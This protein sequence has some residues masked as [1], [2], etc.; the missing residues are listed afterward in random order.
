MRSD[1]VKAAV[2][3]GTCGIVAAAVLVVGLVFGMRWAIDS[4]LAG[5]LPP[6]QE[7]VDQTGRRL[8]T[9]VES[10]ATRV[11]AGVDSGAERLATTLDAST[12][13]LDGSLNEQMSALDA[14]L[15]AGSVTVAQTMGEAFERPMLIR[16]PE[17]IGIHGSEEGSA[18]R[19]R[20]SVSLG[21]GGGGGD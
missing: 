6:L 15:A 9:S 8:E 19:V 7:T 4:A 5:H 20:A 21:G 12:D 2:I 13:E 14:T 16:A 17:G 1:Y 18:V 3:L 11:V 10:S